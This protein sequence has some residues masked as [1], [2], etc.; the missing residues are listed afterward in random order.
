MVI[1]T[2]RL[3]FYMSLVMMISCHKDPAM[4]LDNYILIDG[5]TYY[6]HQNGHIYCDMYAPLFEGI[7]WESSSEDGFASVY[8]Y[9]TCNNNRG[10][11]SDSVA[12][13][14]IEYKTGNSSVYWSGRV[15]KLFKFTYDNNGNISITFDHFKV[16]KSG[17]T[18]S[19]F[20]IVSGKSTCK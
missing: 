20:M 13:V 2:K 4:N 19:S 6:R 15:K 14:Q 5:V 9:N 10:I 18:D 8:V 1:A 3:L 16:W 12:V 7:K 11:L 17:N